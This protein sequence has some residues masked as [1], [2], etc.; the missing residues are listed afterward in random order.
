MQCQ[1]ARKTETTILVNHFN[2]PVILI[3]VHSMPKLQEHCIRVNM[4]FLIEGL[5]Y[6]QWDRNI[7]APIQKLKVVVGIQ[8]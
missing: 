7:L 5:A 3:W 6:N 8:V 2:A 4:C 1:D